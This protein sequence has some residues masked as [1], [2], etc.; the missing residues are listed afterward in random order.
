MCMGS[1]GRLVIKC[2]LIY[3]CGREVLFILG[4]VFVAMRL[5]DIATSLPSSTE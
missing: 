3:L 2:M 5:S 4:G 1:V